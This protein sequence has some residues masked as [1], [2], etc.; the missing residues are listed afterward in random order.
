[1]RTAFYCAAF[2]LMVALSGCAWVMRTVAEGSYPFAQAR[3]QAMYGTDDLQAAKQASGDIRLLETMADADPDNDG[4]AVLAS[5]LLGSYAFGFVEQVVGPSD[6]PDPVRLH[7]AKKLYRTGR[8]YGLRVLL[9]NP[10]FSRA[11]DQ[12]L[13]DFRSAMASFR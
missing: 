7:Q 10:A 5:Q 4:Y 3:A 8:S 9:R 2:W 12:G 13:D 11:H 6:F 1:M